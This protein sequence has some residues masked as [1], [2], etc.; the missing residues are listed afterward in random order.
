MKLSY[1]LLSVL[2]VPFLGFAQF[3]QDDEK[4][5]VN[6]I[7]KVTVIPPEAEKGP[8]NSLTKPSG[9]L[10]LLGNTWT[11]TECCGWSGTW[12]RRPNSN[13]FDARWQHTNGTVVTD[14]IELWWW[15]TSTNA[16]TL[17]R[18]AMNGQYKAT[19]NPSNKTLA[20]GSATWYPAGQTW[21]AIIK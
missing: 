17:F 8:V 6:L 13:L 15:N 14:I 21:S 16:V 9:N 1:L 19:Y 11:V 10:S 2:L 18:P 20:N 7:K 12:T 3:A 5:K 4:G